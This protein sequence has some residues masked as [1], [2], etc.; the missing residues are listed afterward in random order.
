MKELSEEMAVVFHHNIVQLLF[1]SGWAW[2][3]IQ[4]LVLFLT[5]R[6]KSPDEDDWKKLKQVLK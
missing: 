1:L 6:F 5:T 2:H 4:T 3:D